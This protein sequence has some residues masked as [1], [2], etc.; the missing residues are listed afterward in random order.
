MTIYGI[1]LSE[2]S[3]SNSM[4]KVQMMKKGEKRAVAEDKKKNLEK[5]QFSR[6]SNISHVYTLNTSK[7]FG[8][9]NAATIGS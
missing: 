2:N 6:L 3:V 4:L 7:F 9:W 8:N 1:K 5:L